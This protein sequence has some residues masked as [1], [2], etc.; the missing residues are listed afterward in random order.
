MEER[1][2]EEGVQPDREKNPGNRRNAGTKK[3]ER[4]AESLRVSKLPGKIC[5]KSVSKYKV[6]KKPVGIKHRLAV[7]KGT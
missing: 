5:S 1:L 4:P 2:S 6:I 7:E 3:Q